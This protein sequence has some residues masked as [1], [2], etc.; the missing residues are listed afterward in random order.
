MRIFWYSE[1]C[2][3]T[4]WTEKWAW[5]NKVQ[6]VQCGL[7]VKTREVN[8]TA[9]HGGDSCEKRYRCSGDACTKKTK[10]KPCPS[11][12]QMHCGWNIM[13]C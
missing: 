10:R 12:Y 4:E 13:I 8:V 6:G 7:G 11:M 1:H 5:S 9:N 2:Q 3:L